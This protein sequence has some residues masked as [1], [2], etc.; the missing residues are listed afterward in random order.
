MLIKKLKARCPSAEKIEPRKDSQYMIRNHIFKFQKKS[1]KDFS[2]KGDAERT[3]NIDDVVYGVLFSIKKE[4]K[5]KLDRE[6]GLHYGYEEKTVYVFD[7]KSSGVLSSYPDMISAITYYATDIDSE[8]K[9]YHWYKRQTVKGARD[10]ELPEDYTKRIES[11]E[12]IQDDDEKRRIEN[13]KF[14][15]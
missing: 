14:L 5:R 8:L 11:M 2:A 1:S 13:E 10:N 3:N 9:P 4:E 12:S 7:E 15:K 6:E